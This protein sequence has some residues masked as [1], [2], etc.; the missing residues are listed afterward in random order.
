MWCGA[1]ASVCREV[2]GVGRRLGGRSAGACELTAG[3]AADDWTVDHEDLV[4]Y[5]SEL[6]TGFPYGPNIVAVPVTGPGQTPP[7]AAT[8]VR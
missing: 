1:H 8:T 2:A 4:D 5:D 7:L 3:R 6:G